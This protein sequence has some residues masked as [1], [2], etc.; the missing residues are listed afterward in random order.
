MVFHNVV[1]SLPLDVALFTPRFF[2][3]CV[4]SPM[5][6]LKKL[7]YV[8]VMTKQSK[9]YISPVVY[10]LCYFINV[11][12]TVTLKSRQMIIYIGVLF[13]IGIGILST[14]YEDR[15]STCVFDKLTVEQSVKRSTTP[16]LWDKVWLTYFHK[17]SSIGKSNVI[18]S[19]FRFLFLDWSADSD[20][21]ISL[22]PSWTEV[23]EEYTVYTC[24]Y[25]YISI[26]WIGWIA[27]F[28]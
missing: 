20:S 24:V 15:T 25:W 12:I 9:P 4:L 16:N 23:H 22:I 14:Q 26:L 5:F 10:C 2:F 28:L 8:N 1:V 6:K 17:Q 19:T 7:S 27:D 3:W 11:T 21:D 13:N 18:F